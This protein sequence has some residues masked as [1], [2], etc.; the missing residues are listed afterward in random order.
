MRFKLKV[1]RTRHMNYVSVVRSS[2]TSRFTRCQVIDVIRKRKWTIN[3]VE[4]CC[5]VFGYIYLERYAY[6]T[7]FFLFFLFKGVL[8]LIN[9]LVCFKVVKKSEFSIN[10]EFVRKKKS[11]M[12]ISNTKSLKNFARSQE[13]KFFFC[14]ALSH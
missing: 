5:S 1:V 4:G 13:T 14:Q 12:Y 8:K 7:A 10:F 2:T 9:G 6:H 3:T 11:E